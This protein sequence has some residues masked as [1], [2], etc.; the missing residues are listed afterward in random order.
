MLK[1]QLIFE[2]VVVGWSITPVVRH[3]NWTIRK[4]EHWV[5]TGAMGAGKTTLV[6]CMVGKNRIIAGKLHYELLANPNSFEERKEVVHMVSFMDTSKLFRSVNAV[7]YYQ[8]RFNS[9]DSDGHLTVQEYL[10]T[11]GFDKDRA[12]HRELV[13]NTGIVDLLTL[14]RIKLSSGQTRK[15]LL[16]KAILARPKVLILDNPYMGLDAESR[17]T[18]NRLI[19]TLAETL[20]ITF[21]LSGHYEILPDCIT[22][23]LHLEKGSIR[24]MGTL[25]EV[26]QQGEELPVTV[27]TPSLMAIRSYYAQHTDPPSFESIIRMERVHL[28]YKGK[29]ILENVNWTVKP[30][31]KWALLGP[32][33]SGKS[34]LLSLIYGDNPQAYSKQIFL[35]DRKRGSGESIWDIKKRIGF[36]SPELH[37]Y[38]DINF[39]ARDLVLSGLT[40]A[41]LIPKAPGG[42]IRKVAEHLF[43]YFDLEDKIESRFHALSTGE[44][45][46]LFFM[47][48][49]IKAPYL[50]LLDEPFQGLDRTTIDK[51]R[52]LL[53]LVLIERNALIFITHYAH[54][55]PD[56]VDRIMKL[57]KP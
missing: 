25:S 29:R 5:V 13:R 37:A 23:R 16:T 56:S 40:D 3:I 8:Q 38:F 31:Q 36:T 9:F 27:E 19:D 41:F 2:N 18:F 33:G 45:R 28:D 46:L 34:S 24:F 11:A 42:E 20:P 48:A 47:R 30:G 49:L 44:Q 51:C 14:E 43:A 52:Q 26:N 7:H 6:S 12:E 50:L 32:N 10:E 1:P 55:I 54:E 21:I 17:V 35:F 4:G 53:D 22:H 15:M 57:N 39:K